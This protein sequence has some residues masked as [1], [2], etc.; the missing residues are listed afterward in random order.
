MIKEKA[1]RLQARGL[2]LDLLNQAR[3]EIMPPAFM[4][5]KKLG[6][7]DAKHGGK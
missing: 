7:A 3:S 5:R 2:H 1:F 4:A 6:V